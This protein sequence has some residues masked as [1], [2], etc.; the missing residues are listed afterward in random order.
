MDALANKMKQYC[1]QMEDLTGDILKE[2]ANGGDIEALRAYLHDRGVTAYKQ[3]VAEVDAME[4]GLMRKACRFFVL[5]QTD[6]LWKEHLMAIKFLQQAVSLRGYA[7]RDP[8]VE[9]KLEGYQLFLEMTAQIRRN[10]IYN[11]YCFAPEK[12]VQQTANG[13]TN[14]ANGKGSEEMKEKST[15]RKKKSAA[16]A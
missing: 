12:A 6:N 2:K 14:G 3:K 16:T 8:L 5:A 7:Q 13:A 9:Y 1:V 11:L 4:P 15:S 10:V